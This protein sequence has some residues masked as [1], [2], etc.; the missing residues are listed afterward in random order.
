MTE[1]RMTRRQALSL[2]AAAAGG[3]VLADSPFAIPARAAEGG[4][5]FKI[6]AVL[7]LSGSDASGGQ[8]AQRG[9]QF[10]VDTVNKAGGIEAVWR[11]TGLDENEDIT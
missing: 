7:E 5:E 4:K 1:Q 9:Y 6:G 10:W 2:A 11:A 3:A 8:L